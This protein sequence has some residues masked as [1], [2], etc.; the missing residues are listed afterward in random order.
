MEKAERELGKACNKLAKWFRQECQYQK[1]PTGFI[2]RMAG[3]SVNVPTIGIV[4]EQLIGAQDDFDMFLD[5]LGYEAQ[6][7]R[8]L[9]DPTKVKFILDAGW[10][11]KFWRKPTPGQVAERDDFVVDTIP[12]RMPSKVSAIAVALIAATEREGKRRIVNK[13]LHPFKKKVKK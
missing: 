9:F 3:D 1:L 4:D 11:G 8:V 2:V 10:S 13:V 6:V 5:L 7:E 12:I